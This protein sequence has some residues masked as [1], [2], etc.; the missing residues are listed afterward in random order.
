MLS[1]VEYEKSFITSG[2]GFLQHYLMRTKFRHIMLATL[3]IR[4]FAACFPI[5]G[6]SVFLATLP[7]FN[8]NIVKGARVTV[9]PLLTPERIMLAWGVHVWLVFIL[10]L[11]IYIHITENFQK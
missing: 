10:H 4:I 11:Y 5:K 7:H 3:W 9:I 6:I 8:T 2:P 1:L